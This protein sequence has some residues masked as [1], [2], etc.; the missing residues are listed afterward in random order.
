MFPQASNP[1]WVWFW[2]GANHPKKCL[3]HQTQD[4]RCFWK[5]MFAFFWKEKGANVVV[6]FLLSRVF[7][8][9]FCEKGSSPGQSTVR[10]EAPPQNRGADHA[11]GSRSLQKRE[12]A[13]WDSD[14]QQPERAREG[15]GARQQPEH[16]LLS[17]TEEILKYSKSRTCPRFQML[18]RHLNFL[19]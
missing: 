6:Y 3:H 15:A 7:S 8:S 4:T 18:S 1:N 14:R 19:N 17:Q 10:H 9:I 12:K 2:W 11:H 5:F 13:W 16:H